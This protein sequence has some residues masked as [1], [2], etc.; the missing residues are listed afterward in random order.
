MNIPK[1]LYYTES[2]EWVKVEGEIVTIGITAHAQDALGDITFVELPSVGKD[3]K[4][5]NDCGVIESV[6]AAS[7]IFSP[8]SGSVESVNDKLDATPELINSDPFNEGWLFRVKGFNSAEIE[9]LMS[10]SDYE[11]YLETV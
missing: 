4:K 2:H 7:D 10:A 5:D 9:E 6:K 1:D 8:I 11:K 3:L